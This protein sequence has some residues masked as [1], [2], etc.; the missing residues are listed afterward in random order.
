M[1]SQAD[2]NRHADIQRPSW[3]LIVKRGPA[4][5]GLSIKVRSEK[6]K[7][8]KHGNKFYEKHPTCSFPLRIANTA[9]N[10]AAQECGGDIIFAVCLVLLFNI[11]FPGR[12]HCR[13]LYA[14]E[15]VLY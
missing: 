3:G 1:R 13:L 4:D 9:G 5:K 11:P 6:K 15:C 14:D 12:Y 10:V 7:C 8:F 2:K